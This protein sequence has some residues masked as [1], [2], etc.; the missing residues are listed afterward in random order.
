MTER[1]WSIREASE[2]MGGRSRKWGYRRVKAGELKAVRLD[3]RMVI[4]DSEL[5]RWVDEHTEVA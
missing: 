2:R 5:Q 1:M 3:G 4:P